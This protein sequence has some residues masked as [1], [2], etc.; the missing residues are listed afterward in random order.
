[1][2]SCVVVIEMMTISTIAIFQHGGAVRTTAVC[3]SRN[4]HVSGRR[5]EEEAEAADEEKRDAKADNPLAM[6]VVD[7]QTS[8]RYMKSNGKLV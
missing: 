6:K 7:V 2:T 3:V 1:M 5:L 4:L 8:I